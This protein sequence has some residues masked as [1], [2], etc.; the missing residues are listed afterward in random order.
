MCVLRRRSYLRS[1]HFVVGTTLRV[2][3]LIFLG[4]SSTLLLGGDCEV[5]HCVWDF[6]L[7]LTYAGSSFSVHLHRGGLLLVPI[8]FGFVGSIGL[9]MF[10]TEGGSS[11]RHRL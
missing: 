2:P 11:S 1:G 9:G 10:H 5:F 7:Q 8:G 4:V 3:P 6:L